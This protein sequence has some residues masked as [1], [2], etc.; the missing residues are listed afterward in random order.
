MYSL[1]AVLL[2]AQDKSAPAAAPREHPHLTAKQTPTA[3]P[4]LRVGTVVSGSPASTG[5]LVEGDLICK[6]GKA[7]DASTPLGPLVQ[8]A[9]AESLAMDVK[10]IRNGEWVDLKI[11]PGPWSGQGM[12][13]CQVFPM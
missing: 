6:F 8:E 2:A 5:G 4:F 1:H 13:G 7:A 10:V 11:R 3:L 9:V 12:L